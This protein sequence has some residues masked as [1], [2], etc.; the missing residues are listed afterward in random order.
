MNR[1]AEAWCHTIVE[2]YTILDHLL[3]H[4]MRDS[5][6]HEVFY[7]RLHGRVVGEAAFLL[8]ETPVGVVE[9]DDQ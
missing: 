1:H 3:D 8:I 2:L 9:V 6:T 4:F 7:E 5:L